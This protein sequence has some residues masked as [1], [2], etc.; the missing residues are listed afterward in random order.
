MSRPLGPRCKLC[1][2]EYGTSAHKYKIGT[3]TGRVLVSRISLK[4]SVG[5]GGGGTPLIKQKPP[6]CKVFFYLIDLCG[7][8][9][10]DLKTR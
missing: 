6:K 9:Q 10:V 3:L 4:I 7:G 5:G 2:G 1:D 8:A